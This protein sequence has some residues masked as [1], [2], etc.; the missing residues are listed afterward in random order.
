R[1][2]CEQLVEGDVK[3]LVLLRELLEPLGL[4]AARETRFELL[5]E[6]DEVVGVAPTERSRLARVRQLCRGKLADRLEHA[7]T[8]LRLA[9]EA[10][11][12]QRCEDVELRV[13]HGLGRIQCET[14]AEDRQ[15]SE[16]VLLA[17]V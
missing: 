12:D 3:V 15:Q 5:D 8:P 16:K 7:E 10:L 6:T 1:L 13:T 2:G 17:V 14:A 9:H 11:V 4:L